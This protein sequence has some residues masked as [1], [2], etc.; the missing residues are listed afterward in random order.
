MIQEFT[1]QIEQLHP[2]R[3]AALTVQNASPETEAINKLLGW[4]R[5]RGLLDG[6]FRFFG[7]DNCQPDPHHNYTVW[8]SIPEDVQP[9]EDIAIVNF[10]GGLY[11][12]TDCGSVAEISPRWKQLADWVKSSHYM[13]SDLPSLEEHLNVLSD[14]SPE[15][16]LYLAIRDS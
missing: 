15:F 12:I 7:F 9:P 16:K 14:Q 3:F 13:F 5:P 11:A 4:A 6:A 10:P 1:V 8:L 2:M